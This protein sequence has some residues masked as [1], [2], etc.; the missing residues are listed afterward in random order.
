MNV[1]FPYI[2]QAVRHHFFS[3]FHLHP[4]SMKSLKDMNLNQVSSFGN[5][6]TILYL[7]VAK[8]FLVFN[9]VFHVRWTN[10]IP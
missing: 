3:C 4:V 6:F 7:V 8:C 10:I 2:R 9:A 1:N 5:F